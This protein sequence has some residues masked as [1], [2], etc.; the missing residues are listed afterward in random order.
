[1]ETPL[2]RTHAKRYVEM[3]STFRSIAVMM[4]ITSMET[5]VIELVM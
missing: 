1:M 4:E 3:G 2:P 5:V